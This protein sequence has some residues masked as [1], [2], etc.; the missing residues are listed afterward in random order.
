MIILSEKCIVI[1]YP[2]KYKYELTVQ[3]KKGEIHT[4]LAL[5]TLTVDKF[6]HWD[7][8]LK[9]NS[10]FGAA[11][12]HDRVNFALDLDGRFHTLVYIYCLLVVCVLYHSV[13]HIHQ[14]FLEDSLIGS[15]SLS[16]MHRITILLAHKYISEL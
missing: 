16:I 10:G 6:Y 14:V 3:K 7:S 13:V 15:R 1:M 9:Y 8:I 2:Q 5:H 11:V 12:Q 4:C